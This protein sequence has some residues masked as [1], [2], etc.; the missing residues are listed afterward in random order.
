MLKTEPTRAGGFIL[1]EEGCYLSRDKAMLAEGQELPAG[2]ILH[3]TLSAGIATAVGTPGG[4]GAITVGALAFSARIGTYTLV[5]VAAASN[6]GTFNFLA[7][8]GEMIR[9]I[10]VGGGAAANEHMTITIADGS[11]DFLVGDRYTIQ[12]TGGAYT[13]FV[14]GTNRA[15]GILY[16]HVEESAW[17]RACVVFARKGTVNKH[18]LVW[19]VGTT[20]QQIADATASLN[21]RGILLR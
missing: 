21:D 19:P 7:P 8:D 4:N 9:Q 10:T 3:Q 1:R 16:A 2:A 17:N 6:A 14:P 15:D 11:S 20:D 12:V 5:C 18:E 13:A